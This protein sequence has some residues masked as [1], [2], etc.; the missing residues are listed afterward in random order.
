MTN[1]PPDGA[2]AA[3]KP[4]PELRA[5]EAGTEDAPAEREDA[6]AA[7]DAATPRTARR[8]AEARAAARADRTA[9]KAA[10]ETDTKTD[11]KTGTKAARKTARRTARKTDTKADTKTGAKAPAKP[12]RATSATRSRAAA[13]KAAATRRDPAATNTTTR[14]RAAPRSRRSAAPP[15]ELTAALASAAAA[16][17]VRPAALQVRHW[18]GIL[19]FALIVL[20][21]F[22]AT[23]GYLY[24]RAADRFHSEVAFSIRS[25]ETASAAA[26]L[27][28]AI[29]NIGTGTASDADILYE[30]VRS[31]GIVEAIDAELDLRT[32]WGRAEGDPVF[33]I[34]PDAPIEAL[35]GHWGRMVDVAFESGAGIIQITAQ[36]FTAADATAIAEAI[37]EQSSELVNE[38]SNQAR[39]DAIRFAEEELAEAEENLR[40]ERQRLSAFRRENRIVDP[41]GDVA[42][43]SGLLNALQTELAQALVERDMLLS[44][45]GDDDQRVIQANRRITAVEGR[46]EAERASL[47]VSGVEGALPDVVGRYE[48]LLVDLEFANTAYTQ[49]LAGLAAARAEARRQSRYLAPHVQPTFAESA[50]Y[51]RRPLLAGLVGL[52][53]LLGWGV[54]MLIYYNTRDNR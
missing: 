30:Y 18:L 5:V 25:E 31:Q 46:I 45:V 40:I 32:I 53:L 17:E 47:G 6:G 24:T 50:L 35:V 44:F 13:T 54:A 21:P 41:S 23:V 20:I 52:F 42:G 1:S 28:G 48:E 3:P 16:P 22:A 14:R 7:P 39:A 38:L 2:A 27:I 49:T 19:S 29:T 10:Q 34:A 43:Q 26:G 9:R 15:A 4:R 33:T 37:L 11:T 36:A 51:P 12:A 8:T